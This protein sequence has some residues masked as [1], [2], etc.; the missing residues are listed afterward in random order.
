MIQKNRMICKNRLVK[1]GIIPMNSGCGAPVHCCGVG[2]V[3]VENPDMTPGSN[4]SYF[5]DG[6]PR[7][8]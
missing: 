7:D 5:S 2:Q 4:S 8:V 3:E 1:M 6:A